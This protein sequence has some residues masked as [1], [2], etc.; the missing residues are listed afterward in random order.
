MVDHRIGRSDGGQEAIRCYAEPF[1]AAWRRIPWV[2]G[3]LVTSLAS[4]G[5]ARAAD[6]SNN[7]R[8]AQDLRARQER[9]GREAARP[10]AVVPLLGAI[11]D[12]WDVLDDRAGLAR[13]IDEAATSPRAR[14]DV[15]GRAAW[16][17]SL[18][19]DRG[20]QTSEASKQRAELGLLTAFWVSGPFDNE[21]RTGH[22]TI[23]GPEK[24]LV[25]PIDTAARFG[26]KERAVGWRLMPAISAQ[27]MVSLDTMLRPDTNVTAY[28]TTM[29]H[30]PAAT[31]AAVRVGSAGAIKVWVDGALALE[32]DVYRPVRLDQDAAPVELRAGWNRVTVKLS[33]LDG[34][35]SAFVRLTAPD[36]APLPSLTTS[37]A[38]ADFAESRPGTRARFVVADL[39][40]ELEAYA[41]AHPKDAQA[42]S[43]VGQFHLHVAPDDPEQHHAAEAFTRAAKLAPSPEAYRLLAL[44]END[45]NDKRRALEKG[46]S[47]SGGSSCRLPACAPLY[48]A[49]GELYH[50]ARRER[51]AEELWLDGRAADGS[52]WPIALDL[53][54]LASERG[55]PSRA[56]AMLK[57]LENEHATLKVLRAEATLAVRR[58]RRADA[59]KLYARVSDAE[60]DDTDALRELY[61]FARAEGAT[62]EALAFVDRIARARPDVL[63]TALDR[64]DVLEAIGK[65]GEAHEALK[66]ALEVAPE[67]TRLLERDGRLLHRLGRDGEALPVLRHALEL[68]PQNPELRTYLLALQ[69]KEPGTDLA[70]AW[71][72]DVP[73]LM[74]KATVDKSSADPARVLLDAA[75]TRVHPNGLS[76]TYQQRVVE[77]LDERG[78]REEA[79]ADIRYTPDT[80][81]VEI[82]AA[83]VYKRSGEVVE[84]TSTAEHDVSEPWYGLYYDVKA[85]VI[86]FDALEPGD[87]IDVEYVVSDTARRNMFADYFGDLHL[88][89]EEIPRLETRYVLIAPKGKTLYFNKPKLSKV[90][91]S[92]ETRGADTIYTFRA[93][94]VPKVDAEPGMPGFTDV[95]AY[96]HVSTYK[97][98][99]DVATWYRGLVS[100][101]LQSSPQIHDA[102]MDA[103]KGLTDE[104]AKIRAVYDL[105]VR[106]TRYVGL[107]FGIHG[108]QPYRTTQVFAR[109]FGDCKDKASLLVV[110]LRE[111]GVDASLVLARTRRGGDLDPEPASLAPFDHAIVYVPR[112]DLFLDGTAEFSGADEL[113]AQD[114]DIPVLI[115]SE[116]KLRRTPVLPAVRNRVITDEHVT[117]A[118]NGAARVDEKVTVAGEVAHEWRSHYQSPAERPE[119]Y[120]KS[121]AQKHPGAHV[122]SV[123][124]PRLDDLERPVEVHA[125]IDVPDWGRP[126]G[127]AGG[128]ARELVMPALGREADMLRSYARLSSRKHDLVLGFPWRQEDRVTVALPAGFAVKRLP[129]ARSV[130]APFGRFTLTATQKGGAVEVVAALEVDRH[131]I[132]REDYAAF[133]RFCAD[134]D[135]AIGQELV[136]GK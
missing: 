59:Q 29:V 83:R 106:K 108:Y 123:D 41:T 126:E 22:A 77:I 25:G 68:R 96:V 88:M 53:A 99:D 92:Q 94:G 72:A 1:M 4:A 40:R 54:E 80:Q 12:L 98:W 101:Q 60:K 13:F 95:A 125:T 110:M 130:E 111:I 48:E 81:A 64:A 6:N 76:E 62:A 45:P 42:W 122:E 114:Q 127:E 57:A 74:K 32:R 28:L 131:R 8:F 65:G 107:E 136:V 105:V 21:G 27:G 58:G 37:T 52:Y 103:V 118:G 109:K 36:G 133:R 70:R 11:T 34:A 135:A 104:R 47:L 61:S 5:A 93:V 97:T 69:P 102:V 51:R 134:V 66:V 33:T 121:W 9:F 23:Y 129:E 112:Y 24:Q 75:V 55:V 30:V 17:R 46:L 44:A 119:R 100:E 26:G 67:E 15:R 79:Q 113:P 116:G 85:Q 84:A 38:P 18:L 128:E 89:Q 71:A 16:L 39:R 87:V 10:Q 50:R 31:R 20:G 90:E 86:E 124:M 3:L 73:S 2:L 14:A 78:A 49:L 115:V 35:W 7:G 19:L 120:G 43:D 56:A 117:L 132:A 63:Q 82:R 91:Q